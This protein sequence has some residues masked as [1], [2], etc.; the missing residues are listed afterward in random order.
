MNALA[1]IAF[2]V[3][4]GSLARHVLILFGWLKE[5]ILHQCEK[6]GDEE[7]YYLSLLPLLVWGGVFTITLSAWM[8]ALIGLSFPLAG[9]GVVMILAA[10]VGYNSPKAAAQ[11][12]RLARLPRWYYELLDRTDRYERRRIAYMWLRLP[13]RARL[14]YNSDDC[15]FFVWVDLIVMGTV[16]DEEDPAVMP[17]R[18]HA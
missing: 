7:A 1:L 2:F 6:Y 15:A 16:L 5:P 4:L 10:L 13:W 14:A 18:E 9:L 12:H 3:A 8:S 17:E 11:W